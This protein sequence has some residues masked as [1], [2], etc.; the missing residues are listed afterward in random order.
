MNQ[1]VTAKILD[2]KYIDF[3]HT[4]RL[5]DLALIGKHAFVAP[6]KSRADTSRT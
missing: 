1:N 4:E 2:R 5:L 6:I 3:D